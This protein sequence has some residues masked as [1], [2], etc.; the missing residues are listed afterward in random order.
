[1]SLAIFGDSVGMPSKSFAED[2]VQNIES[3]SG[4]GR[5]TACFCFS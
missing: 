1:M 3:S 4:T 2:H 5:I